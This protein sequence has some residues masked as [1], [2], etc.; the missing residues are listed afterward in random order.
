MHSPSPEPV[1]VFLNI[2]ITYNRPPGARTHTISALSQCV[3]LRLQLRR[4]QSTHDE[5]TAAERVRGDNPDEKGRAQQRGKQA[6][7]SITI[8]DNIVDVKA[9]SSMGVSYGSGDR[10]ILAASGLWRRH[11]HGVEAHDL[12][13]KQLLELLPADVVLM[14][15]KTVSSGPVVAERITYSQT[16]RTPGQV[17]VRLAHHRGHAA[18]ARQHRGK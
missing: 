12:L 5:G 1:L 13:V 14:H 7:R 15:C 11:G 9:S 2:S 17:V 18:R 10:H 8:E 3:L 6:T 4:Q 16:R